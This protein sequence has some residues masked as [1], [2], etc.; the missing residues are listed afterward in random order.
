MRTVKI[1]QNPETGWWEAFSLVLNGWR[2]VHPRTFT[3]DDVR[4][5]YAAFGFDVQF[6]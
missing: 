2:T 5:Y 3:A 6:T 1:R 4:D